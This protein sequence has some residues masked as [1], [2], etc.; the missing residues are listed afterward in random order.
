M[1]STPTTPARSEIVPEGW[2]DASAYRYVAPEKRAMVGRIFAQ[3]LPGIRAQLSVTFEVVD[4]ARS[5][6][7]LLLERPLP[8]GVTHVS[9]SEVAHDE[10]RR[11]FRFQDPIH[12]W[13][14]QQSQTYKKDGDRLYTTLLTADPLQFSAAEAEMKKSKRTLLL[15]GPNEVARA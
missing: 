10:I 3:Q 14:I 13:L 9:T 1:T 2:E 4:G 11:V 7:E 8:I 6:A 15:G 12:G 5:L